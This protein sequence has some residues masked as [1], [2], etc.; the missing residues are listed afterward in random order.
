MARHRLAKGVVF[1]ATKKDTGKSSTALGAMS[2]L[3]DHFAS[4][5]QRVGYIKPV[6]YVKCE[7]KPA[8]RRAAGS[9]AERSMRC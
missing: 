9:L 4:K 5:D 6:G 2:A 3:V 1:M 8:A 7:T